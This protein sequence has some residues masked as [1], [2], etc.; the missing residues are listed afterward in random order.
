MGLQGTVVSDY[1]A[2]VFLDLMHRRRQDA[3]HAGMLALEAGLDV[4]LPS[5]TGYGRAWRAVT[6]G[7]LEENVVDRAARGCCTQKVRLGLLD[8]DGSAPP[9]RARHRPGQPPATGPSLGGSPRRASS[10][11]ATTGSLPLAAPGRIALLGPC[12][13]EPRTFIGCYS[14]PNHV[15]S[16]YRARRPG[17]RVPSLLRSLRTNSPTEVDLRAG[18]A[19]PGGRPQRVGGGRAGRDGRR[20]GHRRPSVT[21]PG[22]FGQG[23]SGEGCDAADLRLPG[24]Q[25]E[26]VEACSRTGTPIVLV[27]VSGRPY[28]LG[29]YAD[30]CAAVVQ[31]FMPGEE[32]G[33]ALAGVLSR[34]RQPRAASSPSAVPGHH[35]GQPGTYFAAPGR[36]REGISN[37]DPAPLYPF[38]YG[39]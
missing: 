37:L 23:T 3:H 4:E 1:W 32:G 20:R 8:A 39:L 27:V 36:H 16:R 2:V 34:A 6:D 14:F 31:A 17:H 38:G 35:G 9:T 26:L 13:D 19:D 10:C 21:S 11:C 22:L 15:M 30:R 7:Q 29:A 33:A 25:G 12:A 5:T 18:R 28:A 24:L